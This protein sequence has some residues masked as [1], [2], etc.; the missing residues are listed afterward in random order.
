[1]SGSINKARRILE[2]HATE[3]WFSLSEFLSA[4]ESGDRDTSYANSISIA[5]LEALESERIIES[6]IH[7]GYKIRASQPE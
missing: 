2:E 6:D 7:L 1:M 3:G 5:A 4:M